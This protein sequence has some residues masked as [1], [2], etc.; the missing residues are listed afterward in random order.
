M[1][2]ASPGTGDLGATRG[3]REA[4]TRFVT[5]HRLI[6][7]RS[8]SPP[9]ARLRPRDPRHLASC[10]LLWSLAA[11][12]GVFWVQAHRGYLFDVGLQTD[13][14]RILFPFHALVEPGL[15]EG[16][17]VAAHVSLYY[18]PG[19]TLI[20][21]VLTPFAG[22]F[23]TTKVVQGLCLGL[24]LWAGWLL[25]TSRRV[26]LAGAMLFIFL[27]LHTPFI[28]SRIAGGLPR[29]FA[30]PL[31]A[32]WGAGALRHSERI[33]FGSTVVAA[34]TYP[35]AM[36]MIVAAEGVFG[37]LRPRRPVPGWIKRYAL[38]VVVCGLAGTAYMFT[39]N[40]AGPI[41]TLAQ[42]QSEP[43]F[44]PEGRLAVLPFREP[45]PFI[46]WAFSS[47]YLPVPDAIT[48]GLSFTARALGSTTAVIIV[49]LLLGL[50]VLRW[51]PAPRAAFAFFCAAVAMYGLAR[52]LAFRLYSPIRFAEYGMPIAGMLLAASAVG[53]ILPRLRP[54]PVRAAVRNACVF[55]FLAGLW[56]VNGDGILL[57][58]NMTIQGYSHA[59]LYEQ[60]GRL[61]ADAKIACHPRDAD[62]VT[63]WG[64]RAATDGY[65]TLTVWFTDEWA[66]QRK[67][68]QDT[69]LALY[70]TRRADVL[71]Y[72]A[73]YGVTH[74]L[75][76]TDRYEG[77][78]RRGAAVFEPITTFIVE[79]LAAVEH[80][81]L[82][83]LKAPA[84][85]VVFEHDPYRLIEVEALRH[86]W[87][88]VASEGSGF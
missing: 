13:D 56:L 60:I 48:G 37:L 18:T 17:P 36:A 8:P 27:L 20:Y 76:R 38:L 54:R 71:D 16:D 72:C 41:H 55:V 86:S 30:F 83:L 49:A 65:E 58:N 68:T 35:P 69:L 63:Y 73:E 81:D 52:L 23:F 5:R 46:A 42:A 22:L 50:A 24:L 31:F 1:D 6:P 61:P 70:G 44:G 39:R 32:L 19:I 9:W 66:R 85:A 3:W 59:D 11:V 21:R 34:L 53:L 78:P 10:V 74:F 77:D 88:T 7:P 62:N 12:Y 14:S 28:P 87:E 47:P 33:R 82:V 15:F 75:I 4:I 80:D 57:N 84:D 51:S 67:R 26:G 64:A 43:A 40:D 79:H 29:A 25:A 2:D 45:V